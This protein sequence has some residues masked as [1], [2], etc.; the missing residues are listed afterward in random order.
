MS[1]GALSWVYLAWNSLGF[2]NLCDCFLPHFREVFNYYLLKY[3]LMVFLFVFF[4]WDSYDLNVGVLA[5]SQ[6]SL[7]L[8]SFLLIRFSFFLSDSF[9]YTIL[10]STSLILSS[11][12]VIL[13]FVPSR[14]FFIS[15]SALFIIYWLFLISYRSLLNLSCIFSILV[16]RL[17][18]CDSICFQDFWSFSLSLFGILYQ[19]YSLSLPLWFG[20]HLSCS[21]TFWVFLCLFILFILLFGVAFLY[22]GSLWSSLYCGVSSLWVGLYRWLVKVSWLGKLVS[23]FW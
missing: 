9:I 21:F 10:S 13:L 3:C 6:R 16:S 12:S 8:S 14:A 17:L 19:V 23:V 7:R 5:L 20:G 4:F 22:T 1:W 15:F 18:F 11:A 2:L